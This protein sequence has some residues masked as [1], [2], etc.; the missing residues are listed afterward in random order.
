[1]CLST[2]TRLESVEAEPV[3]VP[4]PEVEPVE[5]EEVVSEP[6][7]EP[8]LSAFCRELFGIRG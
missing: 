7:P 8:V 3:V 1:M 6:E 4:E 5:V 2:A